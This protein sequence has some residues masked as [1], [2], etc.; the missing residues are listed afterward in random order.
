MIKFWTYKNEY[1]FLRNKILKNID[2]TL[3]KGKIFFGDELVRF[4]KNFIN[5]NK[6]KYGVAVGSGTDALYISLLALGIGANDEVITVS[7]TAIPTVSA[8]KSCGAKVKFVDIK[9]DHL[10]NID[11]IERKI[12]KKTK[13]I[14]PVHLYG[15]SCDMD[16]IIKIAK[17]YNL[18]VIEDCAQAQGAKY[19]N[20]FVGSFGDVGC[21]SFYPTKILGAYG[22]GGF[23]STKSKSIA[24][25]L[26]QVR[27]YG[28][29]MN[30]KK[31]K[32]NNKY[33]SNNH[34]IN[35]RID[36]IQ[37]SILNLKLSKVNLWIKRRRKFAEIYI[38]NLKNTSLIL[39]TEN[40][41]NKHVFHLFVVYHPKR[42]EII[43]KLKQYK[44]QININY[45][46][47][48]HKMQAYKDIKFNKTKKGTLPITEKM[49]KGI[50]SLPLHPGMKKNE[51]LR[52]SS[53]LK[54]IVMKM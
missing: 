11:K 13:A 48:I 54:K 52:V 6:F 35:S 40:N 39:P 25:K 37:C 5:L 14:I 33:Y 26:R 43:N 27:F 31:N 3:K 16:K 46:Y 1:K 24:N 44:I 41:F 49:S 21:F 7:N 19:K 2:L 32:Y 23:I 8:I 28:I 30:D 38:N 29:E 42:N 36:E 9:N 47:P 22:D 51:I 17:K 53:V 34:G 15:Q 50:F 18:K 45:P 20:Q 4:E 12:T 10:I